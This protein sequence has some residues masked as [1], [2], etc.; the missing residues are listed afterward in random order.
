MKR[1]V[2]ISG[3]S[4]GLK[5]M[6]KMQTFLLNYYCH[7]YCQVVDLN[8]VMV[9]CIFH[10]DQFT[11][12]ISIKWSGQNCHTADRHKKIALGLPLDAGVGKPTSWCIRLLIIFRAEM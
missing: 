10:Q 1:K 5:S 4:E 2:K 3:E 12:H 7:Y 8:S 9:F 11:V 6:A